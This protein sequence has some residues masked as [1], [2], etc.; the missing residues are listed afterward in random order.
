MVI[1]SGIYKLISKIKPNMFYIGSAVNIKNRFSRHK[2]DLEKNRHRNPILQNHVNK[3]GIEDIEFS[4]IEYVPD[5]QNLLNRE[6][7][8]FDSLFP[9]FNVLKL[10]G[11][12]LGTRAS[13]DTKLKI[14]E[15][16]SK[17]WLNKSL[18]D[19]HKENISKGR[20]GIKANIP[21]ESKKRKSEKLKNNKHAVGFTRTEEH[22][23][24]IKTA[25]QGKVISEETRKKQSESRTDKC[26][27]PIL[28]FSLTG[29][30][31]QEWNSSVNAAKYLKLKSNH[32]SECCSGKLKTA[33][34]FIRKKKHTV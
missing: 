11:S 13:A 5:I 17:Y 24:A 31:I 33:H 20:V 9:T 7:Y 28:Q 12:P 26:T 1:K 18:S 10:A 27:I 34:G 29:E 14:S 30:F 32:I 2:G 16:N 19:E 22:K 6:Q 23:L 25:H 8:Y 15:N 21:E 3:Y 4:I